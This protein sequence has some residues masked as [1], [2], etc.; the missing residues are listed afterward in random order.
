VTTKNGDGSPGRD[1]AADKTQRFR[2]EAGQ[3]ENT[4]SNRPAGRI[5]AGLDQFEIN[6]DHTL[7][8]AERFERRK[9]GVCALGERM[10]WQLAVTTNSSGY[11]SNDHYTSFYARLIE[12]QEPNLR[13]LYELRR[14]PDADLWIALCCRGGKT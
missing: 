9:L 12:H 5:T 14:S 7:A 10:R 8:T 3:R 6:F 13:G 4:V 1:T 11:K 2:K